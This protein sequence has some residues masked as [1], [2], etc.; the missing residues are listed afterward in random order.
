MDLSI[1][2]KETQRLNVEVLKAAKDFYERVFEVSGGC[3][4]SVGICEC[5]DRRDYE[6]LCNMVAVLEGKLVI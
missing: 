2:L 5:A 3:D 1:G 4:H 6:R